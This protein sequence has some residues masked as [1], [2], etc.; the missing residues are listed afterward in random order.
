M[1]VGGLLVG[2]SHWD[3]G[4]RRSSHWDIGAATDSACTGMGM[5]MATMSFILR[6]HSHKTNGLCHPDQSQCL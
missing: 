3:I 5:D 6:H 4:A 2:S 1:G